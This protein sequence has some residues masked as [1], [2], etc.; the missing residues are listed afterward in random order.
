M[1]FT[2]Q[3]ARGTTGTVNA[4]GL[5]RSRPAMLFAALLA[6][7]APATASEV[8]TITAD[9]DASLFGSGDLTIADSGGYT[10]DNTGPGTTL[11]LELAPG[12]TFNGGVAALSVLDNEASGNPLDADETADVFVSADGISFELIGS[13]TGGATT[14]LIDFNGEGYRY[15]RFVSTAT[16]ADGFDFDRVAFANVVPAPAS[17]LGCSRRRR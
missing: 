14:R 11:T 16:G 8:F 1:K 15:L 10:F 3:H 6:A 4:L 2:R 13:I 9:S 5:V 12:L 17:A 7:S